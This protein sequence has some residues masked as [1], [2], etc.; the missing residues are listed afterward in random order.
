MSST[1]GNL[2]SQLIPDGDDGGRVAL[3]SPNG[4]RA[5]YG[6]LGRQSAR[7][8][9]MLIAEALRPGDRLI[10]VAEKSVPAIALYLGALRAG[11]V[12]VPLNPG[13]T[14][15][16][17]AYFIADVEP[18]IIVCDLAREPEITAIC[19]GLPIRVLTTDAGGL[20]S[21]DQ[22]SRAQPSEH[23]VVSRAPEDPAAILYTSGTTG[24]SKGAILSH[25]NLAANAE[26]LRSAWAF[27]ADDVLVHAL[28]IFH[29]HGLFVGLNVSFLSRASVILLPRFDVDAV[30]A[31]LAHATV[32]MGV[33]TYYSRLLALPDLRT[34]CD[35]VRLFISGSAPL[36]PATH[37]EWH[38]RTG[39]H[40]LERYGMTETTM[41]TSNPLE[42]PRKPGTVG[43]P[44]PGVTV[45]IADASEQGIGQIQ[46]A[47]P[48]VFQGYW[49]MPEK[50]AAEFTADGFFI[51]GDLGRIDSDGYVHIIGREKDVIITG[52]YNVYP[53]EVESVIDAFDG[54]AESAVYG[55]PDPDLGERVT[56]AIVATADTVIDRAALE[57][58]MAEQLARYKRPNAV[59]LVS[60]LPRNAMGKVQKSVLRD[61]GP[62]PDHTETAGGA[63]IATPS[64]QRRMEQT[65]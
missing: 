23:A 26:A 7:I 51:T 32:L 33:P 21:L 9:N 58:H 34:S 37:R 43:R 38:R 17:L 30:A 40:I 2:F 50:T 42:G 47:G 55:L 31:Q 14:S 36:L 56:A 5:D 27:T 19:A 29:T 20:G 22:D 61:L 18:A 24:R 65:R 12:Y 35:D 54:V 28:P 41:I 62:G 53:K 1:G 11:A 8:A 49:Q 48:N 25:E 4:E 6:D 60:A 46:V 16:E 64:E 39:H 45:R 52:G 44:L 3:L 15:A 59:M 57:R 10:A 63:C 13:Y